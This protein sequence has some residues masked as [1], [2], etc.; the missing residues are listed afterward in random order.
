VPFAH[1]ALQ[2]SG[3]Q[4]AAEAQLLQLR[5]KHRKV[6]VVL[7]RVMPVN[8]DLIDLAAEATSRVLTPLYPNRAKS[9]VAVVR[10]RSP[11]P[12]P[13]GLCAPVTFPHQIWEARLWLDGL[14]MSFS[15]GIPRFRGSASTLQGGGRIAF[16]SSNAVD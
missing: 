5:F 11:A 7:A 16:P 6:E 1:R 2:Q 4:I 3:Q 12:R 15:S 8:R 14:D 13:L 10:M 9:S